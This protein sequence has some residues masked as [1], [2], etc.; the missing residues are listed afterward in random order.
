MLLDLGGI[1]LATGFG[2]RARASRSPHT[3]RVPL[4]A[5]PRIDGF[6]LKI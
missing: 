1:G 4:I 3:S 6:G 5:F 2:V